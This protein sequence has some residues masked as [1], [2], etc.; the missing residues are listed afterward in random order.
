[1]VE[2]AAMKK[3]EISRLRAF[4]WLFIKSMVLLAYSSGTSLPEESCR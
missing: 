2:V 1:M 4:P 3:A